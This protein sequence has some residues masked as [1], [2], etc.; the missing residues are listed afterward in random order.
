MGC[1][2]GRPR[3]RFVG[4]DVAAP[5]SFVFSSGV[6]GDTL[7]TRLPGVAELSDSSETVAL[8]SSPYI[9]VEIGDNDEDLFQRSSFL[10]WLPAD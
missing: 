7:L 8:V 6:G 4:D 1:F 10:R 3:L 2:L 9:L 5:A